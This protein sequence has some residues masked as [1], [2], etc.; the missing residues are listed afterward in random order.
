MSQIHKDSGIRYIIHMS[1][2]VDLVEAMTKLETL[3]VLRHAIRQER[4]TLH[5]V[6][7]QLRQNPG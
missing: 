7:G 3:R 4:Q 6:L 5:R 1:T 2:A